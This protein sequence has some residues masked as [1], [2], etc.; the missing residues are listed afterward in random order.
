MEYSLDKHLLQ[1]KHCQN[2]YNQG[3][4]NQNEQL[5]LTHILQ[6]NISIF[7]E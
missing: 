1:K 5:L 2:N 7:F 3:K 6:F 4:N